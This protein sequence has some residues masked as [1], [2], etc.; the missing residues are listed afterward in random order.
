M[1]TKSD[2]I[3]E[4]IYRD[5]YNLESL[6]IEDIYSSFRM[7]FIDGKTY[8]EAADLLVSMISNG[9]FCMARSSFRESES[10]F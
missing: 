5:I 6:D 10:F 3:K 2:L 8:A 7:L 1:L 4:L 9:E